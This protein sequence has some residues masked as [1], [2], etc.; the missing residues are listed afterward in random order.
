M[1][2]YIV[3]YPRAAAAF[4][5]LFQG[6]CLRCHEQLQRAVKAISGWG[7]PHGMFIYDH[8]KKV[9]LY[10]VYKYIYIY[11]VIYIGNL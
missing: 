1:K 10:G 3:K 7:I 5:W 6:A 4:P 2:V 9:S 11:M 8:L